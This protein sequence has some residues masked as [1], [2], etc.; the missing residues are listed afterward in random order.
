MK[1]DEP[2]SRLLGPRSANPLTK[3]GFET[4][5]D[6]LRHYPRRYSAPGTMTDLSSLTLGDHVTVMAEVRTAVQRSM[7]SRGGALLQVT[8]TDGKATLGLTFFAKRPGALR[9]HEQRLKPGARG[10]FT[11]TVSAYRS[12]LQLT[13][14]D[15][16]LIGVD[17]E[18][19]EDAIGQVNRPI[20][21]YPASA[22]A[23]TWRIER[24]VR[25][26]LDPLQPGDI[27]EPLP[28]DVRS[29]RG[30]IGA[31]D[32]LRG[33]HQPETDEQ[34]RT[35]RHRLRYEEAFILQAALAQRRVENA[36]RAA[37]A[38][39]VTADGD[40]LL[41]TLDARLPYELT[42]G[43]ERV[44]A[45]IAAD[46]SSTT[47]MQRL[48]QGDVGSGKTLVALRAMLQV[49]DAGGQA[50]LLAPTEVLAA[51]HH[52]N[53]TDLLGSLADAGTL[54][55]PDK[56]TRVA[57]LTGSAATAQRRQ[58][59]LDIA[60]GAAG[61]VVGTHALLSDTTQFAELGLVIV[62]EQHRFGVE[63]RDALRTRYAGTDKAMPHLL[64]MTATPIPRTVAMT[65]FG[66]LDVSTMPEMPPG[67]AGITTHIV[68]ADNQAWMNRVWQRIREDVDA[69]YRV[70]VVAPRIDATEPEDD[71]GQG[72]APDPDVLALGDDAGTPRVLHSVE[73]LSEQLAANPVLA[74]VRIGVLHGRLAPAEKDQVMA[75]LNAG[76][77]DVL[78]ATT[79]IE[80]GVDV[81]DAATMVIM[82]ADRFGIA[83]L[84]QLRGR[85][86]RGSLPGLCL[87]V[88][89]AP[90]ASL[91][92]QRL[93]AFA[94]TTDGFA[95]AAADVELRSEG[96]V[97]GSS[98]S[99]RGSSL[100]LLRVVKDADLIEQARDDART[101][102]KADP[103]LTAHPE[104]A[105]A[106]AHQLSAEK[107]QYLDRT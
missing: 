66:D 90:P 94:E 97:L 69:G 28:E 57:L 92:G 83:Q 73:S 43:Q 72:S 89:A 87:A 98:Q 3:L 40:S 51:Q 24:S 37:T 34:W 9:L 101:V 91:A 45:E 7:R 64:V 39:P 16:V 10:L 70:F 61:I 58:T 102:L 68:P 20:P 81:P 107:Q 44:G 82:D 105:T 60:S 6:L 30:L 88:S 41:T 27:P 86:G 31:F 65:V 76:R 15:Y 106:I 95:L 77:L 33:I 2:L 59:L 25:T 13:H 4:A 48:L 21:I 53:L 62:D 52:R 8:I 100:R 103:N 14:P 17:A 42:A 79:V 78:L 36:Q 104:L 50:A 54:S 63:Q 1:L 19:D 67:R 32:A 46:L 26:V 56:A 80:V 11:G 96:D 47:P 22:S 93:A 71:A 84:H 74:G 55:A 35:A 23:P 49:V 75:D 85:V 5:E 18:D 38:W 12:D 99:G 29:K